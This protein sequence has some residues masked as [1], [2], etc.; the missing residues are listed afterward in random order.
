VALIASI[1]FAFNEFA[2][3]LSR[4]TRSYTVFPFVLLVLAYVSFKSIE[5]L[6]RI[7]E[8]HRSGIKGLIF[9]YRKFII[10]A[11]L[12]VILFS[13]SYHLSPLAILIILPIMA[14]FLVRVIFS[15]IRSQRIFTFHTKFF[16]CVS[17]LGM[18]FL[19]VDYFNLVH[20]IGISNILDTHLRLDLQPQSK[21]LDYLFGR[22][23]DTLLVAV[24]AVFGTLF[25]LFKFRRKGL[26]ILLTTGIPLLMMV[27]FFGRYEDFRYIIFLVPFAGLIIS[28]GLVEILRFVIRYLNVSPKKGLETKLVTIIC[29]LLLLGLVIYPSFPG[30]NLAPITHVA[31]ADWTGGEGKAYVH[32]RA[33]APQ[34]EKASCYLNQHLA[35]NDAL[36]VDNYILGSLMYF[37]FS[38]GVDIYDLKPG[39]GDAKVLRSRLYPRGDIVSFWGVLERYD[40]VWVLLQSAHL[41]DQEIITFLMKNGIN[42]ASEAGIMRYQYNNYY[43]GKELYWPNVFLVK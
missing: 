33:V 13:L 5:E 4:F 39:S 12:S 36:I 37:E 20:I 21:Y 3:Y 25:L 11:V 17:F 29:V 14:Y 1:I 26:F 42:H 35:G 31:Q 27:Y 18:A 38:K 15:S 9:Q 41:Y 28:V 32:R 6:F 40:T 2:I 7:G 10:Y 16:V 34:L 22:Y 24:L 23:K 30:V 8:K 43:K 19:A